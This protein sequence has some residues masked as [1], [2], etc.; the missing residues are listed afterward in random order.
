MD[1]DILT[2]KLEAQK[3]ANPKAEV[4]LYDEVRE[5]YVKF[6][7]FSVDDLGDVILSISGGDE[8]H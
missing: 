7:G 6:S 8:N 1:I 4:V 2:I 3:A 5:C